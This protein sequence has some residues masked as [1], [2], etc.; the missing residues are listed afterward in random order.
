[1]NNSDLKCNCSAQGGAVYSSGCPVHDSY[2][3]RDPHSRKQLKFDPDNINES[4]R[5]MFEERLTLARGLGDS[6]IERQALDALQV[7]DQRRKD[8]LPE[9]SYVRK[10]YDHLEELMSECK[11][12]ASW[13]QKM[14]LVG[15]I[16]E[17][18]NR[19]EN[20]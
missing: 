17:F 11:V 14:Y 16:L 8:I 18:F 4:H 12:E 1:M 5:E 6:V 19:G 15:N 20:K 10:L 7:L 3:L 9:G 2:S 13:S